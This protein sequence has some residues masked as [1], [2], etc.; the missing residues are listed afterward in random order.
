MNEIATLSLKETQPDEEMKD[1][2]GNKSPVSE[3]DG[4]STTTVNRKD[5]KKLPIS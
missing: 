4:K 1:E 5:A 3:D 2:T